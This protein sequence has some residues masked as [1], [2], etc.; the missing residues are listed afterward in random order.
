MGAV[1]VVSLGSGVPQVAIRH[2]YVANIPQP[3]TCLRSLGTHSNATGYLADLANHHNERK[4][5][6]RLGA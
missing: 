6:A 3:K 2:F 5:W 4:V 1:L